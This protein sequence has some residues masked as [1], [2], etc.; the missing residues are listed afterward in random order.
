MADESV[1]TIYVQ[2]QQVPGGWQDHAETPDRA[3]A[4]ARYKSFARE[5]GI[6]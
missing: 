1:R 5:R 2:Q 4:T 6:R 3:V